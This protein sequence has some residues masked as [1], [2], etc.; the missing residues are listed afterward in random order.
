M[1]LHEV[2]PAFAPG[3]VQPL[4]SVVNGLTARKRQR[5]FLLAIDGR[6]ANGKSTLATRIASLFP[7]T[8]IV[9]TDDIAWWH[10]RFGWADLLVSGV[11]EPLRRGEAVSFRPPAWETRNRPGSVDVPAG[12]ELVVIEGVGAGRASLAEK[13]DAVIWVQ[14]DLDVAE[15]RDRDRIATGETDQQGYEEWMAEEVPFQAQEQT[16]AHADVVISG[17][18]TAPC[19]SA[20]ALVLQVAPAI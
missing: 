18:S 11:I 13:V 15:A 14:S 5:P 12:V 19:S 9:H 20:D 16:W 7:R 10:S 3:E 8:A 17:S 6:S 4:A 2:E 1:R